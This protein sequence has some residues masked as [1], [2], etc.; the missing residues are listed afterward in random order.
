MRNESGVFLQ[1]G[2]RFF[3]LR[4]KKPILFYFNILKCANPAV[5]I[6]LQCPTTQ[7]LH[8]TLISVQLC[9]LW[10]RH[11]VHT[12]MYVSCWRLQM[13]VSTCPDRFATYTDVQL[14]HAFNR[15]HWEYYRKFCRPGFNDP[16]KVIIR[17]HSSGY[18][19]FFIRTFW[20]Y[21]AE[22]SGLKSVRDY[23]T[24]EN[25]EGEKKKKVLDLRSD[26]PHLLH[27]NRQQQSHTSFSV[28]DITEASPLS[29]WLIDTMATPPSL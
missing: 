19:Y 5:L 4:S 3:S 26:R 10:S 23:S 25:T 13:C 8:V 27:C 12:R 18:F 17:K 7:V 21:G 14:Q 24:Q 16:K 9:A 6:N 22:K 29:H 28:T 1:P 2:W 15:S 20:S 11:R